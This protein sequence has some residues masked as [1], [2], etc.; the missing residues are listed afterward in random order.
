MRFELMPSEQSNAAV[1]PVRIVQDQTTY[2]ISIYVA[3]IQ[4]AWL[5]HADG[6]EIGMRALDLDAQATFSDLGIPT[7]EHNGRHFMQV[8]LLETL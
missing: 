5:S 6:G 8:R 4:V 2:A 3:D 7:Q 1:V